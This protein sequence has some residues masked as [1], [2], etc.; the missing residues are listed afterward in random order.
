[1]DLDRL[2]D[3]KEDPRHGTGVP[4]GQRAEAG[5]DPGRGRFGRL[6][7][8]GEAGAPTDEAIEALVRW[9]GA[10]DNRLRDNSRIPAGF[11][12]LAQFI[13]HDVSFDPTP[14]AGR[15]GDPDALENFR[16][17]HLDLDSLYGSGPAV[18]PFLYDWK[19]S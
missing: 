16:T 13:D 19:E 8:E 14:L 10:D 12:Y 2:G 18:Q 5:S 17:P 1:M 11:T 7:P 4:R 9:M 3:T 6:F 15:R